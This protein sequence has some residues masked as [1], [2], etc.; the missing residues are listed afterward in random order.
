MLGL[1]D[2]ES[3][4]FFDLFGFSDSVLE[5]DV[6]SWVVVEEFNSL[7]CLFVQV[8]DD[9][10]NAIQGLHL[11]VVNAIIDSLHI[12]TIAMDTRLEELDS[13]DGVHVGQD[14]VLEVG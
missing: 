9:F 8:L 10:G 6:S 2:Q 13:N 5:I 12:L 4:S 3:L 1:S 14:P 7:V 11:Q